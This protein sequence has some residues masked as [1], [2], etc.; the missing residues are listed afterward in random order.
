MRTEPAQ[1]AYCDKEKA[2]PTAVK[3]MVED[4]FW[5]PSDEAA[6][7]GSDEGY[8]SYYSWKEW[9]QSN[10]TSPL[11]DCFKWILGSDYG[12]YNADLASDAQVAKDV[13]NPNEALFSDGWDMFT[14][15]VTIMATALS[16]LLDEGQID[17]DAKPFV[18]VATKRQA[19]PML[20]QVIFPKEV[21]TATERVVTA[22]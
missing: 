6:P 9:R 20:D 15:D 14:L 10:P 21:L 16:Q 4:F 12:A 2:H 5:D 3:L 1:D 22:A 17:H 19:S 18:L 7:F 8:E 13:A 11:T